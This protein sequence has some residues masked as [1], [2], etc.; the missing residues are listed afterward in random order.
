ME[1][2]A[3]ARGGHKTGQARKIRG[4]DPHRQNRTI[5]T[6]DRLSVLS[7]KSPEIA[8]RSSP[9]SHRKLPLGPLRFSPERRHP[10]T[11]RP[12][13]TA[14]ASR[15]SPLPPLRLSPASN[16]LSESPVRRNCPGNLRGLE[17]LRRLRGFYS[18]F[19]RKKETREATPAATTPT[20]SR[21]AMG[22]VHQNERRLNLPD[23]ALKR[24]APIVPGVDSE[25][26]C[27]DPLLFDRIR[28]T[29]PS[30][31]ARHK[32]QWREKERTHRKSTT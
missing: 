1:Q 13:P 28:D 8:S 20:A 24:S 4:F 2:R 27:P 16:C 17:E 29:T 21:T 19:S 9:Q 5:V 6:G 10:E 3:V 25:N 30:L 22:L 14:T 12:E 23:D 15:P 31:A 18:C 32:N 11:S 7:A 26:G